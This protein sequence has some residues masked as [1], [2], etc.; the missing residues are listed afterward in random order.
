M[1]NTIALHLL[2]LVFLSTQSNQ[3]LSL[4][5]L[6][7]FDLPASLIV[8]NIALYILFK[9]VASF[10]FRHHVFFDIAWLIT[11]SSDKIFYLVVVRN[12]YIKTTHTFSKFHISN[13]CSGRHSYFRIPLALNLPP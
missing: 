9:I 1:S 11:H 13:S 8:L 7:F 6:C 10:L 2:W 3:T 4:I 5:H 12:A